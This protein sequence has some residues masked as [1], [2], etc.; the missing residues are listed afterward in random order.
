M[1]ISIS[2][3]YLDDAQSVATATWSGI[4]RMNVGILNGLDANNLDAVTQDALLVDDCMQHAAPTTNALHTHTINKCACSTCSE[5]NDS[6][7]YSKPD[8]C[9]STNTCPS[10]TWYSG[11]TASSGDHGGVYGLARDG[12]VIYGPYNNNNELWTCDD[13]DACNGFFK[14]AGVGEY[15]YA[16]TTFFPYVVGCW[17]PAVGNVAMMPTCTTNGCPNASEIGINFSY[18]LIAGVIIVNNLV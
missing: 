2:A 18:L 8:L 9:T 14:N 12:H 11:W 6:D 15:A 5:K 10:T 13:V 7:I 16:T 1:H 17:G 4:N 3:T